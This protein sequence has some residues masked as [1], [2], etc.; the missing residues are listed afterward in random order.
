M[1]T[2][3]PFIRPGGGV[4]VFTFSWIIIE[5]SLHYCTNFYFMFD[6]KSTNHKFAHDNRPLGL[7]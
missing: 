5:H 7:Q 6:I 2:F 1:D 3:I 4:K